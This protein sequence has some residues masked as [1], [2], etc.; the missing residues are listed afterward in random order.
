MKILVTGSE[1]NIGS[2]LVPYLRSKGHILYRVDIKQAVGCD[3]SVANINSPADLSRAFR[4]FQPEAVYH[5]AAMVS[6]VTCE[7][8]PAL[9]V[10]TNLSGAYNVIQLC[11]EYGA[12]LIYFSTS[13]AY[14][15]IGG[16]L[17]EEREDLQPNNI[18]G[19]TKLMGEQLVKYE[20]ENGLKA[21]I[22]RPFMFYDEDETLGAHRSVMIR[23][24][25]S[26][27]R[28][29]KV[30]VHRGAERSW[31]HISDAVMILEALL[32]VN[33]FYIV[34][35]GSDQSIEVEEIARIMCL[36]LG[37]NPDEMIQYSVLPDR[38]TLTKQP[39]VQLQYKLTGYRAEVDIEHG[40]NKVIN[41]V[42]AR[43]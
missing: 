9:T 12:R 20:V 24:A 42:K 33:F 7:Q 6:R 27:L 3:Y 39:D 23:F 8:S 40:I 5:L 35:I 41:K 28:G 13:E 18:Y 43:L 4:D 15:N 38:M 34:N 21:L 30:T 17:S 2:K 26:L 32:R 25:E 29:Q 11:K 19:L 16:I 31:M 1:G 36:K 14:G 22:V 10:E 37:L